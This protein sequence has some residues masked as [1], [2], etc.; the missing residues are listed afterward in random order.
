MKFTRKLQLITKDLA[1][2]SNKNARRFSE[3]IFS[4]REKLRS[5]SVE[6]IGT[7]LKYTKSLFESFSGILFV[8]VFSPVINLGIYQNI[9][10]GPPKFGLFVY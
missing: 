3:N 10:F 6:D 8:E 9:Y 2:F 4:N 1:T 7:Y 5:T